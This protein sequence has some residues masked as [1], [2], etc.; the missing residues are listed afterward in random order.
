MAYKVSLTGSSQVTARLGRIASND[1]GKVMLSRYIYQT[2]GSLMGNKTILEDYE[3]NKL[4]AE[5]MHFLDKMNEINLG[6]AD[7]DTLATDEVLGDFGEILDYSASKD[8]INVVNWLGDF[9]VY[10][11]YRNV[12]S[13]GV[14]VVS[15]DDNI[16]Y[17]Q[18]Y[19]NG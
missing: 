14:N 13:D 17:T 16:I 9:D 5:Y 8:W 15:G 6:T 2:L 11:G 18:G 7:A 3:N 12:T 4:P 10:F 1:A 19:S